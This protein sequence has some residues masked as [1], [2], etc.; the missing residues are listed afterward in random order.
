VSRSGFNAKGRGRAGPQPRVVRPDPGA[1]TA[2]FA[3]ALTLHQAGRLD[4]AEAIYRGV[5]DIDPGHFDAR[6]ISG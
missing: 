4:E 5:L 6:H 1:V 2:Q 3:E